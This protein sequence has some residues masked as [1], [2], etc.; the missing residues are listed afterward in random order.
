MST[1]FGADSDAALFANVQLLD[2]LIEWAILYDIYVFKASQSNDF[3]LGSCC[4][5][6]SL[7]EVVEELGIGGIF[8]ELA[9]LSLT[10]H[11]ATV[12]ERLRGLTA[13]RS[14]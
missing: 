1:A 14:K 5:I 13:S 10:P 4:R 3:G 7:C 8:G 6:T 9:I 2:T 11:V 12:R